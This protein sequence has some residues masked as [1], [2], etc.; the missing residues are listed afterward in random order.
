MALTKPIAIVTARL[1]EPMILEACWFNGMNK[2]LPIR[3]PFKAI[4]SI[5]ILINGIKRTDEIQKQ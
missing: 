3:F 2:L 5:E 4:D 1:I